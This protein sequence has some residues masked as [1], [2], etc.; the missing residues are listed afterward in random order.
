[1]PIERNKRTKEE[2]KKARN[3]RRKKPEK[4]HSSCVEKMKPI[5]LLAKNTFEHSGATIS[6]RGKMCT[7]R[8]SH[9]SF[10][11]K[12]KKLVPSTRCYRH[13][14]GTFVECQSRTTRTPAGV[15]GGRRWIRN[16]SVVLHEV[17]WLMTKYCVYFEILQT[18]FPKGCLNTCIVCK[19]MSFLLSSHWKYKK[20]INQLRELRLFA[21]SPGSMLRRT[22]RRMDLDPEGD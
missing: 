9:C 13:R 16:M 5:H 11:F 22:R 2:E 17:T 12:K 6:S 7:W 19:C 10:G 1:M 3:K 4:Q 21:F 8:V 15:A 18:I 20:S 14:Q